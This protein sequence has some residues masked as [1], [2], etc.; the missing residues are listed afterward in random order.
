MDVTTDQ[1]TVQPMAAWSAVFAVSLCASTL[2]ATEW[3]PVSL[4]TPIA[5]TLQLTEGQAGQ[6]ISISGLFA[7]L[8]SLFI[9]A[10]TRG[11]DRR[12]VLLGL[13]SITL[14][15]GVVVALAPNYPV[16]ML[17]RALVGMAVG[18]FWSMSAATMI[19]IVPAKD[20][21]RALA[22]LNGGNALATTIAAPMGSFLGQYIGWRGAFFC[23][24]PIAALTLL[25]QF[26]TL[27][28]MP[29]QE[30]AG[31]AAAFKVL[32]RPEVPYGMLAAALFFLGQFSLFTYLRPFFETITRIDVTT[33]SALLL[34]MGVAGL[35]GTSLIGMIVRQ[36]LYT[37][38]VVMP[39]AMAAMAV[40][41]TVFGSSL[42]ATTALM[43][44]WGFVGTAAP[45]GW[46]TWLSK[47][48]PD[49]AEAG[50]GLMVAVVQLA[51]TLGAAG[52]GVLFD[53]S[54]YRATFLFSAVVLVLSSIVILIGAL[55]RKVKADSQ[56]AACVPASATP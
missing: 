49:D 36:R 50:G 21:P 13:T 17:G 56:C 25:W 55:R 26:V 32:R 41:L 54:G 24:V 6:A 30:R 35:V 48:L 8:T 29:S 46:W 43:F 34:V 27:P 23:V 47:A 20:V 12:S 53:G 3:M 4:L 33:I 11:I 40:A 31:A 7:I 42:G 38:L 37:L 9:S 52:G 44:L 2:V 14:V 15:S 39:F 16:F 45:V 1:K 5:D 19:R 28:K 18:G 22:V 51:I 10:S